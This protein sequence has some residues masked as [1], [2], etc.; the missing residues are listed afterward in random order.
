VYVPLI[1]TTEKWWTQ[2]LALPDSY[3]H[4]LTWEKDGI[5]KYKVSEG[6]SVV[7]DTRI[8]GY[9]DGLFCFGFYYCP[10]YVRNGEILKKTPE[11]EKA[12]DEF[13]VWLKTK[14]AP[15]PQLPEFYQNPDF[16]TKEIF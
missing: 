5:T 3:L 4:Y 6:K 14:F 10:T 8:M 1:F 11:F 9:Q 2:Y 15:V 12:V 7:M 16:P 13:F